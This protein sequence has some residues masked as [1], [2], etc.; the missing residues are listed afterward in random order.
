MIRALKLG[1]AALATAAL[2][3]A[4][5]CAGSGSGPTAGNSAAASARSIVLV[6]G[7]WMGASAWDKVAAELRANGSARVTQVELPAHGKDATPADKATLNGYV[8]AVVAALPAGGDVTLVGHSFGG[9]VISAAAEKAGARVNRLVYVSA[10]LP[11]SGDSAYSLSQQ[12]KDSRVGRWWRQDDAKA[13]SPAS[14]QPEGIVEVF[15]ADCSAAEQAWLRSTHRAEPVP[16]LATPV[17]L[18]PQRYGAVA[19]YYV[20]T[21]QDN[22]V[23]YALQKMMI[24]RAGGVAKVVELNTS[25]APMLSQ[26]AALAKAIAMFAATP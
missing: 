13:Y 1:S 9:I 2:A 6:H 19:R 7:S 17:T 11:K 25:H 21:T 16:P 18:T 10:Y 5:G 12:D 3:L 26:P 24:D 20:A 14:I 23:S 15:C 4:A 22:A 8:D